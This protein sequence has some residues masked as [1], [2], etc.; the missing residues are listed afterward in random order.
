M[1]RARFTPARDAR[2]KATA[3]SF[4]G[5]IVWSLGETSQR[6]LAAH[7]LWTSCLMG[8]AAKL[9]PGDLPAPEIA[10]RAFPPC[11]ALERRVAQEME[12]AVPL[13]GPR[14]L[15]TRQLEEGVEAVRAGL[16]A[17]PE[18]GTPKN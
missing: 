16:R 1:E 4:H 13:Q 18:A 3:D 8:E 10:L 9:V 11:T 7:R 2:G 5:G 6:L 17:P 12:G 15:L 14:E